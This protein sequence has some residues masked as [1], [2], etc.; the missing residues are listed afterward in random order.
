MVE[1]KN[2]GMKL[3]LAATIEARVA[4]F[5]V[6]S[7]WRFGGGT[8]GREAAQWG[9]DSIE[10]ALQISVVIIELLQASPGGW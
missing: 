7:F 9:C 2:T 3:H 8:W 10:S 4:N 5:S 6:R 1:L